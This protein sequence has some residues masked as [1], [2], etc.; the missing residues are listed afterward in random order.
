MAK[1][2]Y[3]KG[4]HH[5]Q[6]GTIGH[7]NGESPVLKR[8][9]KNELNERDADKVSQILEEDDR[10][11]GISIRFDVDVS[12]DVDNDVILDNAHKEID[13]LRR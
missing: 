11:K 1:E 5:V 4:K 2:K 12:Q 10:K 3:I 13:D 8:L 9:I 6:V 7:V